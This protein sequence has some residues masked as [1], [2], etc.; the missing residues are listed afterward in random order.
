MKQDWQTLWKHMQSQT[1]V[2]LLLVLGLFAF[3]LSQGM[4]TDPA[5]YGTL[6]R[7]IIDTG[8]WW[9]L[10]FADYFYP[11]FSDHPPGG[12]WL[13]TLFRMI[14]P[15]SLKL[16]PV[17]SRLCGIGAVICL[18]VLA[19]G[20]FRRSG[21][22]ERSLLALVSLVVFLTVTWMKWL[23]YVGDGQLEGANSLG[24]A[25][26]LL[27][28][29]TILEEKKV[30]RAIWVALY[31]AGFWSFM[32]K[33]V[34]YAP[35]M[36]ACVASTLLFP[37][38]KNV[39]AAL[40]LILGFA[41]GF[42]FMCLLDRAAGTTWVR[43]YFGYFFDMFATGMTASPS[44]SPKL[45]SLVS[46]AWVAVT[47]ELNS[48]FLWAIAIWPAL[49]WAFLKKRVWRTRVVFVLSFAYIF[50]FG[51]LLFSALKM[52]HWPV[53]VYAPSTLLI[54]MAAPQWIKARFEKLALSQW[55]LRGVWGLILLSAIIPYPTIS[56]YGRGE[57]WGYHADMIRTHVSAEHPLRVVI[58]PSHDLLWPSYVYSGVFLGSKV[59]RVFAPLDEQL[60]MKCSGGVLIGGEDY[61]AS[62]HER[63]VGRGWVQTPHQLGQY[64]VYVCGFAKR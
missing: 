2:W 16:I 32:V 48:G 18:A 11:T 59:P 20:V 14:H 1:W 19:I 47:S 25:A 39:G 49:V 36:G 26:T 22:S 4:K 5:F 15:D 42:A 3:P 46:S 10:R 41:T 31:V 63:V 33:A 17:A 12:V 56:K 45:S 38:R 37:S 6:S 50:T 29:I 35:V 34:H 28:F 9:P 61:L 58:H 55:T 23:K 8:S 52:A 30:S 24:V 13:M 7:N 44:M 53:G 54:A 21:K 27:F 60:K 64:R 43:E 57:E 51:P 62:V 40:V